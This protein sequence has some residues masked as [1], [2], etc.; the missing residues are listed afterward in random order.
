MGELGLAEKTERQR[1]RAAARNDPCPCGSGLK[2]KH[3]CLPS[4]RG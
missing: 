1:W 4:R 2:F 3:C